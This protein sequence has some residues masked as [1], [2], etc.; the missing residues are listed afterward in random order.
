MEARAS[1]RLL[2]ALAPVSSWMSIHNPARRHFGI[3]YLSPI[4]YE[5]QM[6]EET[7]TT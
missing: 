1:S 7:Q 4:A 2:S 5:T 3:G 6:L